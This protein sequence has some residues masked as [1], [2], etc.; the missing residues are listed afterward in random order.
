MR[1]PVETIIHAARIIKGARVMTNSRFRRNFTG[2][3]ISPIPILIRHGIVKKLDGY[4]IAYTGKELEPFFEYI[5]TVLVCMDSTAAMMVLATM[6]SSEAAFTL[7]CS[8]THITE[9]RRAGNTAWP[10]VAYGS[11]DLRGI[12]TRDRILEYIGHN[13]GCR[14]TDISKALGL[15]NSTVVGPLR[16][17][18]HRGDIIRTEGQW[19]QYS[20]WGAVE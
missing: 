7:D 8:T 14:L 19:P 17:A 16:K 10:I 20:I 6:S 4:T 18:V 12:S 5:Q 1:T 9:S 13:P 11:F 15:S 3:E 2:Q